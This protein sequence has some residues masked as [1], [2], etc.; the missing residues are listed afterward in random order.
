MSSLE[1]TNSHGIQSLI[2]DLREQGVEAGRQEATQ[3]V[4][5]ARKRADWLVSQAEDEAAR[6]RAEAQAEVETIRSSGRQA[7]ELA[8]RDL[9]LGAKDTFARQF[10][11]ELSAL[12]QRSLE[13]PDM[14]S[15]L[16]LEVA[17]RERLE[18]GLKGEALLPEKVVGLEE[19]R[20]DP[21]TLHEGAL[22]SLLGEVARSMLERGISLKADR[23]VEAG[24][25]F[26]LENGKVEV[27]LTD[28]VIADM[29]L[30]HLQ[31]RF[32]ALLEGVVS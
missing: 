15:R 4:D 10:A 2:D 12:V 25:R 13:S 32:R 22:P 14:L 7:L 11:S 26:R 20:A 3:I 28:E 6:I 21:K 29:L 18:E 30:R 1:E 8:Y 5:D 17:G 23:S 19:L 31:P 16:V 9:C 24:V 27:D